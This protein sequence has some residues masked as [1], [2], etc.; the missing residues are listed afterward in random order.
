MTGIPD[1]HGMSSVELTFPQPRCPRTP[2]RRPPYEKRVEERVTYEMCEELVTDVA[3]HLLELLQ[4]SVSL[5]HAH[6]PH[7]HGS[8][9]LHTRR[10]LEPVRNKCSQTELSSRH[11][12]SWIAEWDKRGP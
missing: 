2:G 4:V 7:A 9:H 5:L 6:I 10:F 8:H 12:S 3:M 1:A 11:H